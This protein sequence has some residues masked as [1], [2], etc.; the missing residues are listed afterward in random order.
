MTVGTR[1]W[2]LVGVFLMAGAVLTPGRAATHRAHK[3]P[4]PTLCPSARYLV[5]GA[6][7]IPSGVPPAVDAV[8]VENQDVGIDSGCP[9]S[10]GRVTPTIHGTRVIATWGSCG[11]LDG[12]RL[13][14]LTTPACNAMNGVVRAKGHAPLRF[15]ATRSRCGDGIVDV[16]GGEQCDASQ[17]CTP[18]ATCTRDCRCKAPPRVP[19][20]T[21][22][23]T[24]AVPAAPA[25]DQP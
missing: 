8:V 1:S 5:R 6:T 10:R 14:A 19:L 21:T 2:H 11:S 9:L 17:G 13:R 16:A 22:T 24:I 18:P 3:K 25:T 4:K 7:L 20:A 12:V 15:F 23:T